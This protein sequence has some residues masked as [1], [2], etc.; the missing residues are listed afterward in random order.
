M[1][2]VEFAMEFVL[3]IGVVLAVLILI[4][5]GTLAV[6]LRWIPVGGGPKLKPTEVQQQQI[7]GILVETYKEDQMRELC[8]SLNVDYDRDIAGTHKNTKALSLILFMRKRGDLN[9]LVEALRNE[10]PERAAALRSS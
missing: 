3:V 10:R 5:V 8:A 7:L 6:W 4:M 2:E 9:R 1:N